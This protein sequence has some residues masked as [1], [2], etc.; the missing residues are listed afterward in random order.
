MLFW[1]ISGREPSSHLE[2]VLSLVVI[3]STNFT[4]LEVQWH[5]STR[6][7]VMYLPLEYHR[8]YNYFFSDSVLQ[9]FFG[10]H[11]CCFGEG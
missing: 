3:H 1:V 4:K 6:S 2:E 5:V 9:N 7:Y 10:I 8:H 11:V